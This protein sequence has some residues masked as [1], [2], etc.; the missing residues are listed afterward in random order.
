ML[1]LLNRVRDYDH[2]IISDNFE[3]DTIKDMRDNAKDICNQVKDEIDA[4]K[5]E[6][7]GWS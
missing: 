4:I 3:P 6:I 5:A 7:D 2:L 1:I